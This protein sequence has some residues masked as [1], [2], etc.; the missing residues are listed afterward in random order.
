ML[1]VSP[2]QIPELLYTL[3]CMH[4]CENSSQKLFTLSMLIVVLSVI[5]RSII[6][7]NYHIHSERINKHLHKQL[8]FKYLLLLSAICIVI[9][10]LTLREPPFNLI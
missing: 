7:H 3:Y 6:S 8:Y 2:F 9:T 1:P 10:C 5:Y 4:F